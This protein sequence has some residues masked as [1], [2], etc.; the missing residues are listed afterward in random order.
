ME[1]RST[2]EVSIDIGLDEVGTAEEDNGMGG[3]IDGS[4]RAEAATRRA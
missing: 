2:S 1:S 4:D 3:V